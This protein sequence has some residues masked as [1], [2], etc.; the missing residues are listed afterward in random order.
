[1]IGFRQLKSKFYEDRINQERSQDFN[2]NL[3]RP[4]LVDD[5]K[6]H[7]GAGTYL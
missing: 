3:D 7:F 5:R 6:Y 2:F 1:M 4:I